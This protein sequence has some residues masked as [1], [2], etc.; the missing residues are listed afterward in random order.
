[1]MQDAATEHAEQLC[2]GKKETLD[3]GLFWVI[4]RYSVDI[5]KLPKYLDTIVVKTY[6]GD[7]LKFI[8]PRYFLIEDDKGNLLVRASSTWC[9]LDKATHQIAVDPFNGYKLPP[10]HYPNEEPLPRKVIKDDSKVIDRRTVRYSDIDLNGHLNN[11]KYVDYFMDTKP[12]D[13]YKKYR[14]KHI[15]INYEKEMLYGD[16]VVMMSNEKQNEYLVGLVNDQ[17][18]FEIN[19]DYEER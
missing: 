6:P 8:F 7:D 16:E 19:I 1:M 10:E 15:T 5:I 4:S 9:V 14:I 11:T 13:F 2:V 3:K 18:V 17:R 12:L